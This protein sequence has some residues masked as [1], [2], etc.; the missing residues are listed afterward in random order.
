MRPI[1]PAAHRMPAAPRTRIRRQGPRP[2]D[3]PAEAAVD[4][5]RETILLASLRAFARKNYMRVTTRELA[6][7]VGLSEPALY[8]YFDSK[9]HLFITLIEYIGRRMIGRWK[10]IEAQNNDP[11]SSIHAIGVH[12]FQKVIRDRDY[13]RVMF[14]AISEVSEPEIQRAVERVYSS[15]VDYIAQLLR[16]AVRDGSIKPK[17]DAHMVAWHFLSLGFT[18]NLIGLLGIDREFIERNLNLWGRPLFA[19]LKGEA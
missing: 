10:E 18:L 12:H 17:I 8:K 16:R 5:R 2:V 7:E 1:S 11:L 6:E 4:S 15:F 14:Q 19:Y 9:R 13:T 3:P